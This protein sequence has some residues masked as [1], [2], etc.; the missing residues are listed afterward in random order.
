MAII[1]SYASQEHKTRDKMFN[2]F[3]ANKLKNLMEHIGEF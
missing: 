3:I 1:G 2:Y